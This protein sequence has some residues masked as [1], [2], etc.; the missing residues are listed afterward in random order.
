[1]SWKSAAVNRIRP[2]SIWAYKAALERTL[3]AK[4]KKALRASMVDMEAALQ[5]ENG[6]EPF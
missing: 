5:G 3:E 2:F 6:E 1:M 4:R